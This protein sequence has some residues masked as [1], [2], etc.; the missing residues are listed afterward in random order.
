[1]MIS[2][3]I[4]PIAISAGGLVLTAAYGINRNSKERSKT[5]E[6]LERKLVYYP[7]ASAGTPSR[8]IPAEQKSIPTRYTQFLDYEGRV[9]N[10]NDYLQFV[11][12]GNSMQFC[13]INDNDLIF[14]KK[15]FSI[16]QLDSLPTPVVIRRDNAP[17]IETQFKV[18]RAW[19][20]CTIDTCEEFVDKM[21]HSEEF[22]RIIC[23]IKYFDG[24]EALLNDF[25]TKRLDK[26][27]KQYL[28]D[29]MVSKE[30]NQIIVSTTFH[31]DE[32][33]IRFSI[34]PICDVIG[35]VYASFTVGKAL[36]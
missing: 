29:D 33:K 15:D 12:K 21:V 22:R 11:V 26:Y 20:L 19:G 30:Y 14:V 36:S 17:S 35:V 7:T 31:T 10:S 2:N 6:E 16:G 34:H 1:M 27:R 13:G 9:I 23:A 25:K 24:E 8:S 28:V 32:Q 3:L 18:R 5:R 4:L